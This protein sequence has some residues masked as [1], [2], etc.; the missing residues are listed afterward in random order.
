M[1]QVSRVSVLLLNT[2]DMGKFYFAKSD[3]EREIMALETL[4]AGGYQ[5]VKGSIIVESLFRKDAAEE[6]FD[7]TNNP[8]REEERELLYGRHRS[9]S[10]G[11]IVDVDGSK[12][13]CL[14]VGWL[15]L[16]A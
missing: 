3:A 12:F 4:Q 10:S 1:V 13:L 5:Y 11:D 7:L 16:A 8:S 9:V 14:P 2:D 6:V 15:R